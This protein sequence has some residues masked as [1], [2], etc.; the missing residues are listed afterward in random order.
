MPQWMDA[1]ANLELIFTPDAE[2]WEY[3]RF[4]TPE[5]WFVSPFWHA[6]IN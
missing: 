4:A 5:A 6:L 2:H 1:H 3:T